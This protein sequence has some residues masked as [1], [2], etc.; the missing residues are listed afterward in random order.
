MTAK[1]TGK[2]PSK[3]MVSKAGA[4][5][6]HSIPKLAQTVVIE[7]KAVKGTDGKYRIAAQLR[8]KAR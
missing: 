3:K 7:A 1:R 6:V 4:T 5:R 8:E 2:A